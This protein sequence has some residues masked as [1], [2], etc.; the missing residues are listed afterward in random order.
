MAENIREN[1]KK[2]SELALK[3]T[4]EREINKKLAQRL[5]E[6]E[7]ERSKSPDGAASGKIRELEELVN[8]KDEYYA[9]I[10]NSEKK[11]RAGVCGAIDSLIRTR[12]SDSTEY[13]EEQIEEVI[14]LL[15]ASRTKSK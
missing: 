6:L 8:Y 2:M 1:N 5:R 14:R 10:L 11:L 15:D 9:E 4:E 7:A 3:L 13:L 12:G